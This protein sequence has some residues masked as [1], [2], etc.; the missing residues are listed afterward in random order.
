MLKRNTS[1]VI[2]ILTLGVI[3]IPND[4]E[5]HNLVPKKLYI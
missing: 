3:H 2:T 4:D 1:F 5:K